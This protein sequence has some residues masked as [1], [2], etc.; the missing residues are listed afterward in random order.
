[1]LNANFRQQGQFTGSDETD[2]DLFVR[3]D[4]IKAEINH[5]QLEFV[6]D[7]PSAYDAEPSLEKQLSK[8]LMQNYSKVGLNGRPI[9]NMSNAI[10]VSFGLGLIQMDLN[11]RDKILSTSMWSRYVSSQICFLGHS[12]Q[13]WNL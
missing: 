13:E 6:V 11:E 9:A 1:M 12:L 7:V 3:V 10:D 4:F 8:Q 2:A 5:I